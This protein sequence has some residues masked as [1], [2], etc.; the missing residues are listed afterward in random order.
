MTSPQILAGILKFSE[1]NG[2]IIIVEVEN[3]N[4]LRC[5][6]DKLNA[7][8]IHTSYQRFARWEFLRVLIYT[9]KWDEESIELNAQNCGLLHFRH[10]FL[11]HVLFLIINYWLK[12]CSFLLIFFDSLALLVGSGGFLVYGPWAYERWV[13]KTFT[14]CQDEI[15]RLGFTLM[16]WTSRIPRSCVKRWASGPGKQVAQNSDLQKEERE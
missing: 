4:I 12:V 14:W 11:P 5:Y 9:Q 15:T 3:A 8:S 13:P 1:R 10:N 6:R 7:H 2:P 16:H